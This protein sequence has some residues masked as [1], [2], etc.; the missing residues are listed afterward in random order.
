MTV[1]IPNVQEINR[2]TSDNIKSCIDS[3]LQKIQMNSVTSLLEVMKKIAQHTKSYH[4]A[5]GVQKYEKSVI[6]DLR[7]IDSSVF[8][9]NKNKDE[10]VINKIAKKLNPNKA[11]EIMYSEKTMSK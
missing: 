11:K 4:P 5:G 3:V 10:N 2:Q 9:N 1:E 8:M 6:E 7:R